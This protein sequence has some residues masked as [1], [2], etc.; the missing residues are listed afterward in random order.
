MM[1]SLAVQKLFSLTQSH[2]SIFS[3]LSLTL[4]DRSAKILLQEMSEILLL[5][6]LPLTFKSVIYFWFIFVYG[7]SW[8]PIF[9]VFHVSI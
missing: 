6:F 3:F 5:M 7:V 1:I 2:L 4:G 9:I 8:W